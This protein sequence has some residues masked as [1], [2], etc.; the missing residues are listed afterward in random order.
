MT[1]HFD[2]NECLYRAVY[3]PEKVA[4]YWK[5]NGQISSAAF[6][7]KRGLSVERAGGRAENRILQ[8][9]KLIF[10]GIIVSINV[11]DCRSCN[12]VVK[13]MP[14]KRSNYH[15]EIHGTEDRI[16]LSPSQCKYLANAA[17]ILG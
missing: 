17:R 13:Y 12:A 10:E 7:D 5:E 2:Y 1:E 9:M 16:V 6:K 8:Y 14:S 3:P 4:M 11:A 15:S